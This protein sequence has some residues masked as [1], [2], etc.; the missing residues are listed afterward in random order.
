MQRKPWQYAALGALL[1]IAVLYGIDLSTDGIEDVYGPVQRTAAER[2]PDRYAEDD[3][4][5]GYDR[6]AEA[7]GPIGERTTRIRQYPNAASGVDARYDDRLPLEEAPSRE[8]REAEQPYLEPIP[9]GGGAASSRL[10]DGTAGLLQ[11]VT[12]EGIKLV[13]NLFEAITK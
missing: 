4:R 12:S 11:S 13:V 2:L 5:Y 6:M 3:Y 1:A 9:P 10:A 8:A 7:Y